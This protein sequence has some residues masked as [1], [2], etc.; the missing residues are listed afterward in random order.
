MTF[1]LMVVGGFILEEIPDGSA[2]KL[3]E[4]VEGATSKEEAT[5]LEEV[6][7][8]LGMGMWRAGRW[9]CGNGGE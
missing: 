5:A 1:H 7:E 2:D 9:S 3:P 4:V 8:G 6:P